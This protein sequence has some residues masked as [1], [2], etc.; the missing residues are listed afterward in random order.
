MISPTMQRR[1]FITLLGGAAAAWPRAARAQQRKKPVIGFL[2][3][4][5]TEQSAG[6][7]S[8]FRQGLADVGFFVT[9]NVI[10]TLSISNIPF[11]PLSRPSSNIAGPHESNRSS[12]RSIADCR[13]PI[14]S[15][16]T[17]SS[18]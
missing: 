7:I 2:Y 15:T 18:E 17:S 6:A 11:S 9:A 1:A 3:G 10:L 16:T 14:A 13:E 4:G 5:A 8:A 12:S